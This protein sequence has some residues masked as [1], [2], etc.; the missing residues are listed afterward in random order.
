MKGPRGGGVLH[1]LSLYA[2]AARR[3]DWAG[4]GLA[5]IGG[6]SDNT[7]FGRTT[8][9]VY[10]LYFRSLLSLLSGLEAREQLPAYHRQTR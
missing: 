8:K 9:D 2:C 7:V 10:V 1:V 4:L 3:L 5:P 6:G